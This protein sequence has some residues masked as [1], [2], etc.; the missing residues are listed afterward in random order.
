MKYEVFLQGSYKNGTNL[1]R[2]SDVDVV[3]RLD[4]SLVSHLVTQSGKMLQECESHKKSHELWKLFRRHALKAMKIKFGDSV[5][6]GRKTLKLAK[7]KILQA[8]ADLVVTLKYN[9][10]I[11]LYLPDKKRWIVSFPQLHYK[12]GLK[13]EESTN[14]RFKR[15]I[16]MFKGVRN[17]LLENRMLNDGVAPSYFIECLLHNVPDCLFSKKLSSSYNSILAWLKTADL[18]KFSCQNGKIALFG[19]QPEQWSVG[20]ALTFINSLVGLH[21]GLMNK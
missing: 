9:D 4:Y 14:G 5:T 7:G 6:D 21:I 17:H 12:R 20:Q 19:N 13:K 11:A 10:G 18:K 8:K 15:T 3:V 1:R 2:D 16:R